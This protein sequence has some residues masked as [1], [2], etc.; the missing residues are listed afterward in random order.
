VLGILGLVGVNA[1]HLMPAALIVFGGGLLLSGATAVQQR[2][3]AMVGTGQAATYNRSPSS[4][5]VEILIGLAAVVLGILSLVLTGYDATLLLVGFI[6]V[7]GALLMVGA[8][9]SGAVMR[10]VTAAGTAR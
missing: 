9:F 4:A 6:A 2:S 5:G 1:M 7:G 8:T 3:F 10:L